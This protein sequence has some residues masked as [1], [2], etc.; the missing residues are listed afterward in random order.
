MKLTK[1]ILLQKIECF[2]G[3][4]RILKLGRLSFRSMLSQPSPKT[5]FRFSLSC[6][7]ARVFSRRKLP[8]AMAWGGKCF[9][10]ALPLTSLLFQ[11]NSEL[12]LKGIKFGYSVAKALSKRLQASRP[13][14][15]LQA[16]EFHRT[17]RAPRLEPTLPCA[18]KANPFSRL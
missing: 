1:P 11:W 17:L 5:I 4:K 16:N 6:P 14:H 2:C 8:N 9:Q 7:K 13:F 18:S 10:P 12:S 15:H 3:L